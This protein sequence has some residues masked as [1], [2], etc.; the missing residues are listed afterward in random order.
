[1]TTQ[2]LERPQETTTSPRE[3]GDH[4]VCPCRPRITFCGAYEPGP[5]S[6]DPWED[7][8]ICPQ[9]LHVVVDLGCPGCGCAWN[10]TCTKCEDPK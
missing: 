6:S 8:E 5:V 2:T 9:C 10:Q 1:M 7:D 3:D 4:I